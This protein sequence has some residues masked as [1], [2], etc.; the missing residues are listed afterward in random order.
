VSEELGVRYVLEGSIQRAGDRIRVTAQMVD[1]LTGH[2][3]LAERYD[4]ETADL[5]TLQ[6][7]IT[8]KILSAVQVKLTG[9]PPTGMKHFKGTH[10]LD[11][12]L[13]FQEA[14]GYVNRNTLVDTRK[15]QQVAEEALAMCPEIPNAYRILAMVYTNYYWFDSS[16][17]PQEYIEK[18]TELLQK[19]LAMDDN[20]A[21]AHGNLSTIYLQ[22]REY[23]KAI[24]EGERAVS[25][26]QGSPFAA[27]MYSKA[28][29]YSGRPEEAIPLL[30]KAIRLNPLAPSPFYNDLGLAFRLTGRLEE[31]AA[32]YK[33][34][35][36]RAPNDFW[37]HAA[38]A[39]I[40]IEMGRDEEARAAAAEVLRIN[41]KFSI[42]L[43]AKTSF[44]KDRSI[45]D[46]Y[47]E[48][49]RKAGLPDKSPP[50]QP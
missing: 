26:D 3:L 24:A 37:I 18:A 7:D 6:D 16:K 20:N 14:A 8:L 5:F 15:A 34:S 48:A 31:A 21:F 45:V 28:L 19:T 44:S 25:L 1:A 23:D 9:V 40:F 46:K 32:L 29:V 50:A 49:L 30:E 33:K 38:L 39:T 22:K 41:P 43:Y 13:K 47:S 4:G 42:E 35:L 11:C 10:G 27:F 2:Q 12:L 17:P 36:L